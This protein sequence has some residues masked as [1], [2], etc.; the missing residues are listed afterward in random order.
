MCETKSV[1][2]SLYL[3]MNEGLEAWDKVDLLEKEHDKLFKKINNPKYIGQNMD[4]ECARIEEISDVLEKSHNYTFIG[5]VGQ[6][7]PIKPGKGGGVLYREKDG[8]YYAAGGTKGYRWLE[9]EMVKDLGK[10]NDIDRH[11]YD[12]LVDA[13]VESISKYGDFEW[14]ISDNPCGDLSI[15]S[16]APT[17]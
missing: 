12:A 4:A 10:E 3:D 2:G 1:T 15:V 16:R 6:F 13:A 14:F 9:S 8:K 7:C 5:K 11:Y 17:F